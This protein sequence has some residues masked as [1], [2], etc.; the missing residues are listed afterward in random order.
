MLLFSAYIFI[1]FLSVAGY[2]GGS[3][4]SSGDSNTSGGIEIEVENNSGLPAHTKT[5][6]GSIRHLGVIKEN[7]AIMKRDVG[8]STRFQGKSIWLFGDTLLETPNAQNIKMMSNSWSITYDTDAGDG[9]DGFVENVDA[10]GAP[11]AFFPLTINEQAFNWRH[12]KKT[13]VGEKCTARWHI[14]PGTIVLDNNKGWAYVFYRK[15]RVEHGAFKFK[16]IGH[17]LTVWKN[18]T[19]P[20]ERPVF[21]YIESFP[22]LFFSEKE[23]G[24][25]SAAVVINNKAFIYGCELAKG[26][27]SKPCYLAK[28]PLSEILDKSAWRYYSGPKNWSQNNLDAQVVFYGND[29]MSVSYNA[30][31]NRYVA[32][33]SEPLGS[34][35]M[36]RTAK[37]PAGP[38]SAPIALF[39]ADVPANIYGWVYDFIAHPE[40]SM[41]NGKTIYITYTKKTDQLHS[42]L[43]LV[44]VE[45]E[46]S[47]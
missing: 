29:M 14:W 28:V 17:S 45:L 9:I 40:F 47:R 33:Y 11:V 46:F 19:E 31:L 36:M 35:A 1:P 23:H 6:I 15:V 39:T 43:Q 32:V 18:A 2:A 22:T 20:P 8:F 16:H 4:T 26:L 27:Y 37:R 12:A 3:A 7:P 44:A 34:T 42:Q 10:V 24:F 38:W 13:C 25:D 5:V 21:N 30:Y 41:D